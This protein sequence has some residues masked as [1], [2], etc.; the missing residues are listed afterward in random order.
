M[1]FFLFAMIRLWRKPVFPILLFFTAAA[2]FFAP[3]LGREEALPPAAVCDLDGSTISATV[4]DA[5][6]AE[7]FVLCADEM[8]LREG[9]RDGIY[10]CGVILPE[11]M[12][13]AVRAGELD[14]LLPFVTAPAS[15]VPELYRNHV[16]AAV[17][18]AYAPYITASVLAD[19]AISEEEVLAEYRSLMESGLLFS[20]SL[21]R[22]EDAVKPENARALT[23]TLGAASL[24]LF[25]LLVYGSC[26]VLTHDG[27][28][29]MRRIGVRKT[30]RFILIPALSA[31]AVSAFFVT[32][33]ALVLGAVVHDAAF[34]FRLILPI[35]GY[36][37]LLT[38]VSTA[39]SV[40]FVDEKQIQTLSCFLLLLALVLAPIYTDITLTLPW[41]S[42]FRLFVPPC[43][44]W[45]AADHPFVCAAIGIAALPLALLLLTLRRRQHLP[46]DTAQG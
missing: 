42:V 19:T 15:Y 12:E 29:F 44:L 26:G 8:T 35:G 43:W 24:L 20:F 9:V 4:R 10:D 11:G 27:T 21:S 41:T 6:C 46:A 37:L 1:R 28:A 45:Y 13:A 25:A 40:L 17:F 5:L 31:R 3:M 32:A 34:L 2:I 33:P 30:M 16:T 23:Y 38:A 7:G 39:M 36:I 18:S 22:G 14:A